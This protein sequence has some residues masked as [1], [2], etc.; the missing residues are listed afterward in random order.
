MTIQ[1][2]NQNAATFDADTTDVDMSALY[3]AF[4]PMLPN[5]AHIVD[6][7]CG[8]GRDALVFAKLGFQV[9]AFDGSEALVKLAQERMCIG[10]YASY[11]SVR[12]F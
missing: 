9:T 7:G 5:H 12:H 11:S 8:S 10:R 3:S 6:A 4:L 2:Y 1:Y